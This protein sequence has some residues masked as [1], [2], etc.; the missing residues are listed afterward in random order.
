M[1]NLDF[2]NKFFINKLFKKRILIMKKKWFTFIEI[3]VAIMVFSIWVFAVLSLL[4]SNLKWMDRNDLKLQW[5]LF[6]KEWLE[7]VYNMRDSNLEREL[8]R[9]CILDPNVYNQ[10]LA[11]FLSGSVDPI[12]K[13]CSWYFN[14][15]TNLNISYSNDNYIYAKSNTNS[16]PLS[17]SLLYEHTWDDWLIWYSHEQSDKPTVF[18]RYIT[19]TWV[20]EKITTD[21]MYTL[22]TWKILKVSSHVFW[23][24]WSHTWEV[25]IDSFI[26]NY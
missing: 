19:F 10:K 11:D 1:Y 15:S 18:Y 14:K 7:L 22:D 16:D 20:T 24:R 23:D 3:L 17:W 5:T 2:I 9:N 4:T 26:W 6:A 8:P 25:V 12:Q 13:L 21:S